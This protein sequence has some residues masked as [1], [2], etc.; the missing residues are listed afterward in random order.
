MGIVHR[1]SRL[2]RSNLDALAGSPDPGR[3]VDQAID[4]LRAQVRRARQDLITSR[5]QEKR[6]RERLLE[7]QK[8]ASTWEARAVLALKNHDESLARDAL[9]EKLSSERQAVSLG[10]DVQ[11]TARAADEL[12]RTI[13]GFETEA[14]ALELRK[15][16]LVADVLAARAQTHI[17][18]SGR[19]SPPELD[20]AQARVVAL[21]AE[22]EAAQ[23]L[24]DP[25]RE[26]LDARFRA[27]EAEADKDP[28][29]DQLRDLKRQLSQEGQQS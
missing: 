28:I 20:R 17:P 14:R 6:L 26:A 2:V 21:E 25:Q 29:E 3:L 9:R 5:G 22:I 23:V 12:E 10:R 27:L 15:S 13:Q 19:R 8:E 1:L 18:G 4:E 11:Q 16:A 24:Q 7:T